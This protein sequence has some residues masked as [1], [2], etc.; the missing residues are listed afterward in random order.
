MNNLFNQYEKDLFLNLDKDNYK[1]ILDFLY[2]EVPEYTEDIVTNYLDLFLINYEE[3]KNKYNKLKDKYGINFLKEDISIL[4]QI[5]T[6]SL[7]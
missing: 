7:N 2:I 1:K 4:E 3:F 6:V 5:Y